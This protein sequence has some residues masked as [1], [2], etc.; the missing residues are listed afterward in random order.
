MNLGLS[1]LTTLKAWLLPAAEQAGTDFDAALQILGKGVA[2]SF[3]KYCNRKFGRVV[4][5]TIEKDG[6]CIRYTLPRYPLE[7]A[8]TIETRLDHN[9]AWAADS[10]VL[11]EWRKNSGVLQF[12]YTQPE[13]SLRITWTGGY[14]FD[15][16]EDASGVQ[17]AGST[18]L[19]DDLSL[20]FQ[21]QCA[22]VWEMRDK[23]GVPFADGGRIDSNLARMQP[24]IPAVEKTLDAY[25]RY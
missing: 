17:P 20:A 16:T 14:W 23:E 13:L 1:N 25:R 22:H 8:P 10:D 24:L 2:G 11:K 5:D 18:L 19:P 6:G 3:E 4:S 12:Y 7:S 15:D 9:D 21:Q